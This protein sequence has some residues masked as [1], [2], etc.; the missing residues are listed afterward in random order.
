MI[1][2]RDISYETYS[3]NVILHWRGY[4]HVTNSFVDFWLMD[5]SYHRLDGPAIINA[6]KSHSWYVNGVPITSNN[7]FQ[8]LAG[9]SDEEMLAIV[10]KYGNIC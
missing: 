8:R 1:E 5:G 4:V 10:L 6:D 3:A 7:Q 2:Y 9:I